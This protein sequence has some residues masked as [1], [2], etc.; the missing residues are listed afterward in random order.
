MNISNNSINFAINILLVRLLN[1][2]NNS[3]SMVKK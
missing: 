1:T 3:I 2:N